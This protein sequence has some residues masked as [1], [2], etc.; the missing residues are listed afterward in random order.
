VEVRAIGFTPKRVPVDLTARRPSQVA[1]TLDNRVATLEGVRVTD[2]ATAM[3]PLADFEERRKKGGFGRFFSE[4]D[5]QQRNAFQVSDVLRTVPGL[6]LIPRGGGM[7]GAAVQGRG[8]CEMTVFVDG[9]R[10]FNGSNDLDDV[11]RPQ[12]VAGIEVYNG[13]AGIPAQFTTSAAGGCGV[14]A[15][16]TKRGGTR[17]QRPAAPR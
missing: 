10:L 16:W 9:N 3:G 14:V 5:V 12:D 13:Q 17:G 7:Q 11:V 1:V 6:R 8:N 15:V 4:E 2:R